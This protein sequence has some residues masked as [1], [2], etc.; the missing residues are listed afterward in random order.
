VCHRTQYALSFDMGCVD[1]IRGVLQA[2][3]YASKDELDAWRQNSHTP[4]EAPVEVHPP[5]AAAN[6][7]LRYPHA[8][9]ALAWPY[10]RSAA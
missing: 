7:P 4:G 8:R 3:R 9:C 6:P 5:A 10:D 1:S 2:L